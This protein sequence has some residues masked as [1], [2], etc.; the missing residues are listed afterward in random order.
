[1]STGNVKPGQWLPDGLPSPLSSFHR[2]MKCKV[3]NRILLQFSARYQNMSLW[4]HQT[5]VRLF[6]V[7]KQ[8]D[9]AGVNTADW[10]G[11]CWMPWCWHVGLPGLELALSLVSLGARKLEFEEDVQN[12][13]LCL[14]WDRRKVEVW[15]E[16]IFLRSQS[17]ELPLDILFV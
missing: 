11:L 8:A 2:I 7:W 5:T 3:R 17:S 1:M 16:D 10:Q 15:V 13:R 6:R 12:I 4:L 14:C 9:N